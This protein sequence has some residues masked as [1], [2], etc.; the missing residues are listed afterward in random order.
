MKKS[1]LLLLDA[2]IVIEISRHDLW[3]RIV[4]A[5]DVHLAQ[6]VIDE[7]QFFV[8]VNGDRKYIDLAAFV[9]AGS[10]TVFNLMPSDLAD[11]R[12]K[13]AP[14][15]F[16]KLDP[17]ETESLVLCHAYKLGLTEGQ[18]AWDAKQGELRMGT[19]V[20]FERQSPKGL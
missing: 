4:A 14:A 10:V 19:Y 5:C 11:F 13:F 2:N 15:Y 8:D 9:N 7:A 18:A 20:D 17:G 6:T 16:E 1:W 3:D 12:A